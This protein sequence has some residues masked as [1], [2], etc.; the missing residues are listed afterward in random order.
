LKAAN[1]YQSYAFA[2]FVDNWYGMHEF[3]YIYVFYA[4]I[5]AAVLQRARQDICRGWGNPCQRTPL[6]RSPSGLQSRPLTNPLEMAGSQAFGL[7]LFLTSAF[8]F[9][10]YTVW[11]FL[12]V[13]PH[14]ALC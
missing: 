3:T 14:T 7:L 4:N 9:T 6:Y 11:V 2:V 13:T 1:V 10:Y 12:T 8:L 5:G